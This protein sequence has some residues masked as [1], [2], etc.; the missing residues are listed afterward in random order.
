[1]DRPERAMH[2]RFLNVTVFAAGMTT[3]AIELSASRLLGN[4]FGTS[5]IVWANIIGLILVYLAA[6]YFIGGRWAD[7]S[8]YPNTFYRLI[9]WGAFTAG[10]VPMGAR[11]VLLNAAKA[12]ERLDSAV[13]VGSFF[14]VLILF[15][16]PVTLLGCVSP[17]AIRLAITDTSQAGRISGRI[18]AIS[19]M[20][21]ILGT[22]LPVLWLIPSIGTAR[23]FLVFSLGLLAVALLGL[24]LENW[25]SAV[26]HLWMPILLLFLAVVTLPGPVKATEGQIYEK[27]S[28]YNYIQVVEDE[29]SGKRYLLLNEGQGIHSVYAPD[30][31]VTYGTWDYFLVAPFFNT[32]PVSLNSVERLGLVGLAAGTIAKQYTQVFGPI[33]IDGWEIDPEIV[34]TGQKLFSMNEPNLNVIVA[35]GRWG[36]SHSQYL[37]SVIGVDAYRLPY[38]PWQLTTQEF[39]IEVYNHLKP[40][41]VMVINVGRT[42]DDRRLIDA[43]VG[44]VGSVFS[45]VHVVDVPNTFNTI[46]YGTVQPSRPENLVANQLLLE[47]EGASLAL[48]DSI[49]RAIENLQPTPDSD[50][51]FTDDWSPIERLTNAMA[52]QFILGGELEI[53]R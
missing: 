27:E 38:I 30:L 51:V 11:P 35:D 36:L 4:V 32:P 10:L 53:L 45:S 31:E 47:S 16:I 21:S 14:A 43:M 18:Y 19:T 39:F 25:R 40:D 49:E 17:F 52:I 13:M 29:L 46:L 42:P 23:T 9:A 37:Y 5:N 3:L 44:T 41:G 24:G 26:K 20:G 7:H 2:R 48:L 12:V 1:M 22:F 50:I 34:A 8:P 15:S 6:G 28:A 33:P